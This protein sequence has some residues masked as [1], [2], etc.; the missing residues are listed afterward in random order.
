M[1]GTRYS[2][3]EIDRIIES[4]SVK[5]RARLAI[6]DRMGYHGAGF[7]LTYEQ[8]ERLN[9]SVQDIIERKQWE[10]LTSRGLRLEN[11]FKDLKLILRDLSRDRENLLTTLRTIRDFE[12]LEE[13]I[14]KL[15]DPQEE[16]LFRATDPQSIDFLSQISLDNM[17]DRRISSKGFSL[18]KPTLDPSNHLNLNLTGED[19]LT[20]RAKFLRGELMERMREYLCYEVAMRQR[21]S[22]LKLDIP[23]YEEVLMANREIVEQPVSMSLRFEGVQDNRTYQIGEANLKDRDPQEYPFPSLSDLIEDYSVR[24]QD[25]DLDS[26]ENQE[27]I[28]KCYNQL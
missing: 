12:L 10:D 16:S 27:F 21:I 11:G 17:R 14:N 28:N 20:E 7:I 5:Q 15:I 22:E 4:G 26:E 19:S 25:I 13:I 18:I 24:P 6:R 1:I 9:L 3:R 23:E 2:Q 8:V